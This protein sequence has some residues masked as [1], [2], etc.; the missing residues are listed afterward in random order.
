[1][2]TLT[3]PV[4]IYEVL[5]KKLTGSYIIWEMWPV[6]KRKDLHLRLMIIIM[7]IHFTL[8]S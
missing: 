5:D 8:K 4:K 7:L 2:K 1:M 3:N 6:L